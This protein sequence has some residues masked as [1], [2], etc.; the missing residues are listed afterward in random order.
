MFLYDNSDKMEAVFV[1][2]FIL[3][4]KNGKFKKC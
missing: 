1:K 2:D 3:D 4:T